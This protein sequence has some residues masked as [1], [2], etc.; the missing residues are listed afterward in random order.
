MRGKTWMTYV[1]ISSHLNVEPSVDK[2]FSSEIN[3]DMVNIYAWK[4]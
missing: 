3:Q 1:I 4:Y 2:V